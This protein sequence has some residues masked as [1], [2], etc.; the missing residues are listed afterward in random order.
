M[1]NL[2]NVLELV[3][4]GL[5]NGAFAKQQFVHQGHEGV[6][7]VGANAG[8]QFDIE[9]A[10]QFVSQCLGDVAFIAK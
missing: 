1:L 4:D 3:N 10:Q 8:H 7:H 5:N 2:R 6:F 9:G